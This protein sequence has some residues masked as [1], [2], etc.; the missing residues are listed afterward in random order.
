MRTEISAKYTHYSLICSLGQK[1]D[2]T[3]EVPGKC[4]V[5]VIS[6]LL[7]VEKEALYGILS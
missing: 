7:L 2:E 4:A 1:K 3:S 5:I 6:N